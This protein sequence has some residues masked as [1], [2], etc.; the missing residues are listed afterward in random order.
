MAANVQHKDLP[1]AELH[2]PKGVAAA[3]A[4]EVYV[5]DGAASGAWSKI[6]ADSLDATGLN[7]G[8]T[9][10]ADGAGAVGTGVRVWK[11]LLGDITPKT[12]GPGAPSLSA[13]RGGN[14]RG[15]AYSAGDDGDGIFHI[16]HDWVPG[17]DLY[18]HIHWAHNG[19]AISGSLVVN[20]YVTYAK[21]FGGG[22]FPVEIAPSITVSTPNIATIPQYSHRVDEIQLSSSTPSAT[23]LN[24]SL[25]ETD[26]I[27]M[28][29]F[30]VGT[31]PT[32]TGGSPNEPFIITMDLHYLSSQIG[33]ANK[34]PPFN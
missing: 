18:L 1:D 3:S 11:D 19:T 12:S 30:D 25:I 5:A 20:L 2:E 29:H 4:N 26:G 21:G 6:T 15:F 16:P 9:F 13:F 10:L 34:A 14:V 23:Q 33:T 8:A 24:T 17:T 32:I 27:I 31:I 7:K 28:V 22:V